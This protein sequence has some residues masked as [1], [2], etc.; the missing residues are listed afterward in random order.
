MRDDC[1]ILG[2]TPIFDKFFVGM[3]DDNRNTE[4]QR[5]IAQTMTLNHLLD[6]LIVLCVLIPHSVNGI[7]NDVKVFPLNLRI[8]QLISGRSTSFIH[9][10]TLQDNMVVIID[11]QTLYKVPRNAFLGIQQYWLS[12]LEYLGITKGSNNSCFLL[13]N[14]SRF[15]IPCSSNLCFHGFHNLSTVFLRSR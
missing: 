11:M 4:G 13:S 8:L 12:E 14:D 15:I 6:T 1:L 3:V 5:N 2:Q 7:K 10:L 9:T